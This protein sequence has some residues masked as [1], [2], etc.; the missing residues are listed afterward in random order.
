MIVVGILD[1]KRERMCGLVCELFVMYA[2]EV[3]RYTDGMEVDLIRSL[4]EASFS[5]KCL[6]NP[7][8][9]AVEEV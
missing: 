8:E 7:C 3:W 1:R 2:A 6:L 4:V 5:L 9:G